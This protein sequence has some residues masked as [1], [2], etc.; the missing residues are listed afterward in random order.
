METFLPVRGYEGLYEVSNLGNVQAP[1][2]IDLSGAQRKL[3]KLKLRK[4][5]DGYIKAGLSINKKQKRFTVHRLVYLAF[6][7][8]I[9]MGYEINHKNGIRDDNR[10]ENLER[11]THQENIQYS[12][13]V[14]KTDYATYGNSRMT[15][16]Q[17]RTIKAM[18]KSGF[19][20]KAIGQ[21][22]GFGKSQIANVVSGRSW[23]GIN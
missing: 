12:K 2:K 9:P 8:D 11:L 6:I 16:E 1:A 18:Y 22:M 15:L 5:E 10:V 3:R 21:H 17:L 20:C 14:L 7:G 19:T 13:N 4:N 23:A